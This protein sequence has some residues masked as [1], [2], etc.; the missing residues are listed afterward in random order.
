MANST[1]PTK[2]RHAQAALV[3]SEAFQRLATEFI[4]KIGLI[5]ETSAQAMSSELGDVAACAT[6]LG[7]AIELYLKALLA[8]LNLTV[9]QTHDLR[10]LYDKIPQSVRT[11]IESTY[12]KGLAYHEWQPHKR[13]S[14]TLAKG[15]LEEPRWDDHPKIS[16]TLPNLLSRSREM[17]QS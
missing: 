11:L 9:P 10:T 6:N 14:F 2:E 17:F 3:C 4:P 5:K 8:Q 7:F 13:V 1:R 16:C 15:P 12:D